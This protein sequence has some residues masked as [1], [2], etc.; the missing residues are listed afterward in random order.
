MDLINPELLRP[1]GLHP[2]L[3]EQQTT[4]VALV[5]QLIEGQGQ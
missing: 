5:E 4:A 3:E 2:G 1:D